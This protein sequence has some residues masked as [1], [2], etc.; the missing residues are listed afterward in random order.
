M[1]RVVKLGGSPHSLARAGGRIVL[2]PGGG[3]HNVAVR[4]AQARF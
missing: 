4:T 1:F 3:P 2:V